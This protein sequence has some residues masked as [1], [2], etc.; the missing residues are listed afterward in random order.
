MQTT[1]SQFNNSP[2]PHSR[3]QAIISLLNQNN[4]S[5]TLSPDHKTF[6]FHNISPAQHFDLN[7]TITDLLL[8]NTSF[9]IS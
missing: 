7:N 9:I 8:Q 5:F 1:L 3:I 4:I 2:L 6:T